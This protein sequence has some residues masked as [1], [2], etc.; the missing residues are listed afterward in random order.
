MW[1][2]TRRNQ[3]PNLHRMAMDY[4]SIP[5][6]TVD[7]ERLFSTGR[8]LLSYLRNRLSADSVHSILCLKSWWDSDIVNN[9]IFEF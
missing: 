3:Y 5:A 1:W 8:M 4:C 6:T 9:D 7:V 2:Y